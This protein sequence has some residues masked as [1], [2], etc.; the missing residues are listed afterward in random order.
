MSATNDGVAPQN[1]RAGQRPPDPRRSPRNDR[2]PGHTSL[3]VHLKIR[4]AAVPHNA[5]H[6]YLL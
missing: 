1:K 3:P 6:R 5:E 2:Y 4:A